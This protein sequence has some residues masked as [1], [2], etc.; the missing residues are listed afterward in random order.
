MACPSFNG[1]QKLAQFLTCSSEQ[2]PCPAVSFHFWHICL[3]TGCP[4]VLPCALLPTQAHSAVRSATHLSRYSYMLNH[5]SMYTH[6]HASRW[7]LILVSQTEA[8]FQSATPVS[9]RQGMFFPPG[10][11]IGLCCVFAKPPI[12]TQDHGRKLVVPPA[13]WRERMNFGILFLQPIHAPRS[14]LQGCQ[15]A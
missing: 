5:P 1:R 15:H 13:M 2:V 14:A 3:S 6:S 12:Y 8:L 4:V 11:N 9:S 10:W 7:T